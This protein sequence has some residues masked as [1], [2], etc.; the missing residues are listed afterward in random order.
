M[1]DE[2]FTSFSG[3]LSCTPAGV[4]FQVNEPRVLLLSVL[5]GGVIPDK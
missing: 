3:V 2:A 4:S 1:V 5:G